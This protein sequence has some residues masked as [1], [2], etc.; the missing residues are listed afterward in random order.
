MGYDYGF[1]LASQ[2]DGCYNTFFN[3]LFAQANVP[4]YLIPAL[5]SA[6]GVVLDRQWT[7]WLSKQVPQD[8]MDELSGIKDGGNARG[9]KD[10]EAYV[11]RTITLAN[12]PG[13]IGDLQ[14]VLGGEYNS[15]VAEKGT[16]GTLTPTQEELVALIQRE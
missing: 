4:K 12:F 3:S 8:Y 9:F 11:T 16:S 15:W 2:I 1:L 6:V 5:K 13:S 10:L 14:Y 7:N